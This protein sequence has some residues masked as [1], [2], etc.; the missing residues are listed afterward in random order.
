MVVRVMVDRCIE[1]P[2][3]AKLQT[4]G[5][6]GEQAGRKQG[7][8]RVQAWRDQGLAALD[9]GWHSTG[10]RVVCPPTIASSGLT[11]PRETDQSQ[12]KTHDGIWSLSP[13]QLTRRVSV[14]ESEFC[15][16]ANDMDGVRAGRYRDI[17]DDV[18]GRR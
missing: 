3:C 15:L 2:A 10:A 14:C 4:S 5:L 11:T 13:C 17:G 12:Y 18:M 16:Q 1:T 7:A 8:T 6:G 9:L